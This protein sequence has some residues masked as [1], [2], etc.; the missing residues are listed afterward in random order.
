MDWAIE[1]GMRRGVFQ[2]FGYKR[3]LANKVATLTKEDYF[4]NPVTF[5][6]L[7]YF[8]RPILQDFFDTYFKGKNILFIGSV[9]PEHVTGMIPITYQVTTPTTGAYEKIE[10]IWE[11]VK[12]VIDKKDVDI[13]LPNCGQAGRVLQ[14]RLWDYGF[15][16]WSLDLG[17][18]FDAEAGRPTRT[19]IKEYLKETA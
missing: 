4:F 8:K 12:N 11:L 3:E 5:Q 18:I 19:W 17:S 2:S 9:L 10:K 6:Y 7:Y 13:I 14:C 15:N 16:G 1:P